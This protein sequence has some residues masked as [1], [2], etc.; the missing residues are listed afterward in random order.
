MSLNAAIALL[1]GLAGILAVTLE[2]TRELGRSPRLPP[3]W[4]SFVSGAL[5][6]TVLLAL[7]AT[8]SLFHSVA[9]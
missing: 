6:M 2:V 5:A 3:G 9:T 4:R 7:V 1:L 8:L